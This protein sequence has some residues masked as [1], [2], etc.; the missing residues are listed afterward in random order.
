MRRLN[1]LSPHY[2]SKKLHAVFPYT[3]AFCII[4][5]FNNTVFK[6][7]KAE[8]ALLHIMQ[9]HTEKNNV[10]LKCTAGKI[11]KG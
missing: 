3:Q 6:D 1:V 5:S 10:M 2:R 11:V 7:L 4:M 9:P 8:I